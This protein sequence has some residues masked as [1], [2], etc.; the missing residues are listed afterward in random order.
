MTRGIVRFM[1]RRASKYGLSL[2]FIVLGLG[3][4]RI[5]YQPL[6]GGRY[7]I[8]AH[9]A[10]P[11]LHGATLDLNLHLDRATLANGT[12]AV[13]LALTRVGDRDAW[14][15][16]CGTMS[17][18][19]MLEPARLSPRRFVLGGNAWTFDTVHADCGGGGLR[20]ITDDGSGD[21]WTF[22]RQ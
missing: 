15:P 19:A 6:E 10:P 1:W 14:T 12:S 22:T 5:A 21:R 13:T 7:V 9:G 16:H 20:M 8:D 11:A 4:R 3:C 18:S 2:C 17:S